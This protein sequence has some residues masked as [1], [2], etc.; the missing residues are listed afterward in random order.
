LKKNLVVVLAFLAV[1]YAIAGI[2]GTL[3]PTETVV[4]V[5]QQIPATPESQQELVVTDGPNGQKFAVFLLN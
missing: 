3:R 1:L 5:H 2:V 4:S